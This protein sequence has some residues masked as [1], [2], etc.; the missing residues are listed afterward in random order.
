MR[1]PQSKG[2]TAENIHQ[3]KGKE[4]LNLTK[5]IAGMSTEISYWI[6]EA[7]ITHVCPSVEGNPHDGL[8]N[9]A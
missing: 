9:T 8:R 7:S 3:L 2:Q 4:L 6:D 1:R 5:T